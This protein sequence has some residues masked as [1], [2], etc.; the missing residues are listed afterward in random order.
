MEAET[1]TATITSSH[2]DNL[3]SHKML[4]NA[5]SSISVLS[6]PKHVTDITAQMDIGKQICNV[7]CCNAATA[8][9]AA[10]AHFAIICASIADPNIAAPISLLISSMLLL[11]NDW[12]KN[13]P[14]CSLGHP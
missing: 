6:T 10:V 5:C 14:S 4:Q 3:N 1:V 2:I 13:V 9:A 8:S 12:G 7:V 11:F